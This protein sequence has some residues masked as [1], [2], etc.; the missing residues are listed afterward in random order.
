MKIALTGSSSVGKTTLVQ[1]LMAT[2]S[3]A[4]EVPVTL[5][6]DARSLLSQLGYK[7]M[8]AMEQEQTRA[9]QRLYFDLKW[10]EELAH[11]S[12][13]TDR[14][15]VDVAAYWLERDTIGCSEA[16]RNEL[17]EP[18]RL[19]SLEYSWHFY[20]PFGLVPF[21]SDGYRSENMAFHRAVDER[22]RSL[23]KAW[24]LRSVTLDTADH[25]ERIK[26]VLATVGI[27]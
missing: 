13:V 5:S 16:L 6:T 18:C 26:T 21:D 3:F 25:A 27:R 15:F 23:L 4:R 1:S 24:N 22:I 10:Q 19:R 14:S 20:L 8:D 12:F 11:V 2:P 17:I 9:F 7:S